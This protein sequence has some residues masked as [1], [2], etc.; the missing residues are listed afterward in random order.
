LNAELVK[1]GAFEFPQ[2]L[3]GWREVR[4]GAAAGSCTVQDDAPRRA[5]NVNYLRLATAEV[6]KGYG[7]VNEGFR[8]MGGGRGDMCS[9]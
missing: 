1:N 5:T 9:A 7:I 3:M 6:D 4:S 2:S 8:G